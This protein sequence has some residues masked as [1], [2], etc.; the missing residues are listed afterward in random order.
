MNK[1]KLNNI[2][3]EIILNNKIKITD[4]IDNLKY[5]IERII[6]NSKGYFRFENNSIYITFTDIKNNRKYE[7]V[8]YIFDDSIINENDFIKFNTILGL[9]I[10]NDKRIKGN[11][12][13]I[14]N[15]ITKYLKQKNPTIM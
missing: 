15:E 2:I 6:P 5:T 12:I 4:F 9:S 13:K 7:F 3:K 11:Y 10:L 8:I 1:Q 14:K